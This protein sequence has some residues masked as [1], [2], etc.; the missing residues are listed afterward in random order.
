MAFF[1]LSIEHFLQLERF[2][3]ALQ[4]DLVLTKEEEQPLFD[5]LAKLKQEEPIQ[6]ILGETTFMDFKIRVNKNVLIP[7]PE[8]AEPVQW[9]VSSHGHDQNELR[10]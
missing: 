6:Y 1:Y 5:T 9:P 2:V 3:L 8:T 10:S 7:R 4:P